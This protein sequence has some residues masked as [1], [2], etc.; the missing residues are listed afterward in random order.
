M[1][2]SGVEKLSNLVNG[3]VADLAKQGNAYDLFFAEPPARKLGRI[4]NA[5]VELVAVAVDNGQTI[6]R[7]ECVRPF[8]REHD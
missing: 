4:G 6:W 1:K 3:V 8:E 5:V 2:T 7:V